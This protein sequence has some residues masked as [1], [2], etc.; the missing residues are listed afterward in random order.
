MPV[1][2]I[3]II[4]S[5]DIEA[6]PERLYDA[7]AKQEGLAGWWTPQ[8]TA[9]RR[10]GAINEFRFEPGFT[11][12]LRVASLDP[13]TARRVVG[14]PDSTRL[15]TDAHHVR[16]DDAERARSGSRAFCES[17]MEQN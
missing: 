9:E 16:Y 10:E 5:L 8:A 4:H 11:L 13:G 14:G 1:Y 3:D 2:S 12:A 15:E 6:T 17:L 7:I